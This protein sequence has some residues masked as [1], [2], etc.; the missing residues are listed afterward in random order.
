MRSYY[1]VELLAAGSSAAQQTEAENF[2]LCK[3]VNFKYIREKMQRNKEKYTC[4]D[5]PPHALRLKSLN[6]ISFVE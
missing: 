4:I 6:F 1:Q 2:R 3:K 5:L